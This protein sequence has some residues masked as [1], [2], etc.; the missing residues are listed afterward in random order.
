[1]VA[2]GHGERSDGGD[3]PRAYVRMAALI[4][5]DIESGVYRPGTRPPSIQAMHERT[6]HARQ[7]VG[8]AMRLL[9]DEGL[10][11]RYQGLGY[12]VAEP[13]DLAEY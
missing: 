7:T 6:G 12:Y 1:M 11:V 8:K 3:D 10:L 5:R 9:V 2:T 4:R 13:S